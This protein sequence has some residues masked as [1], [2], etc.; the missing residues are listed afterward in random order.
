MK[1]RFLLIVF[2][3]L[4]LNS[5]GYG[6]MAA[7]DFTGV[8]STTIATHPA[9][10]Y[11]SGMDASNLITRGSGAA[12][13]TG[14]NSWRTVGFQNNGISTTN[15]DYFQITLS[16]STGNVMSLSSI[17]ARFAGTNSFWDTPGVSNQ[18]AYS[19]DGTTFTLIGSPVVL[20]RTSVT[21]MPQIDLSGI[22]ALQNVAA[23]TTVYIRYYASGQTNTGGWG[24][25]S[26]SSGAY[27][28][29]I[30]GTIVPAAITSVANG[31]WNTP[32]TWSCTCV[33]TPTDNVVIA[34]AHTVYTTTSLTRTANTTVHGNFELRNGGGATGTAFSYN[35]TSGGLNFNAT[36]SYPVYN[37]DVFWPASN[38]PYNVSVL[39]GGLTMNAT[40][41]RSV[42]GTFSVANS[43]VTITAPSTLTINGTCSINTGG[44]FN[45][46]PIYGNA[47]L[48]RYNTGGA[49][50][51]FNEWTS[52]TATIGTTPGYPNNVQITNNTALNYYNATTGPRAMNGNLTIDAG[53][54]LSFGAISTAGALTVSGNVTNA[55]TLTLGV[56]VGDDIRTAGNFVNTGTFNGNDRAIWFTKAAPGIQTVSS[57]TVP[58]IIPYVVTNNGTTVR[59]LNNVTITAPNNGNAIDFRNAADIIDLNGNTLTVGSIGV[60]SVILGSGS[61]KGSTASD[62]VLN[63][64]TGSIGTVKMVT[65]FNLRNFTLNRQASNVG[66]VMGSAVTVNGVLT[67]TNGLINLAN[68]TMTIGAS[69]SI[70]GASANNYIIADVAN[71]TNASLRKTTTT[72]GSFTFPIGDGTASA[73]G[74]QYSPATINFAAGTFSSAY[75]GVAVDDIKHPSMDA[76]AHYITRYW[77]VTSSG[78]TSPTYNFV[79]TYL[80]ADIVGTESNSLSNQWNGTAWLNNGS[81]ISANTLTLNGADTLPATNHFSAGRRDQ[82]INI[83][84]GATT[85]LTN[86]TYNFGTVIVGSPVDVVFT[87]QNTG[88][89]ILSLTGTAPT[90]AGAAYSV[91]TNYSATS[92]PAATFAGPGTRTFTI[93]FTPSGAGTFTG[94]ATILSNDTDEPSYIINFTGIGQLPTPEINI[95]AASGGFG[96]I[97]SGNVSTTNG[98]Q[99]TAF[100]NVNLGSNLAKD[101][102]IQN[103]GTASLTLSGTPIVSIGGTNPGDFVVTTPP[104]TSSVA[105]GAS[106]TFIITFTPQAVGTRSAIVSIA[107]NDSDENPYTYLIN[108]TGV[109]LAATNTITPTSGPVGTEVTITATTNNLT[110]AAVTISGV[111]AA[112]VTQVS[113]TQI[114]VT[115]PSGV[116][117]GLGNVITTNSQGCQASTP[118]TVIDNASTACQG[119]TNVSN[120]FIS[121]VTDATYGGLSYIEIYNRTGANVNLSGYSLQFFANGSASS[122]ATVNLT[123]T[124][125]NGS[126]FTVSTST[127]GAECTT[128][129]GDG[130]LANYNSGVSGINFSDGATPPDTTVGHDHIGLYQGG[131]KID[132][133]GTYMNQSWAVSLGIGDRGA[134]FRRKSTATVPNVTYSNA[135]WDVIDWI[136][137]GA[138][139][140]S[141]N[142]YSNIGTFNYL[143]GNPPTV[144]THPSFTPTCKATSLMVAGTEGYNGVGDTMELAYQWYAVAPNTATWTALTDNAIYTGTTSPTLNIADITGLVGYQYYCQIRESGITCYSASNAVIITPG[145]STTWQSDNTWSNGNPTLDKA[146][147]IDHTYDTAN[148]FSPSFEACSVTVNNGKSLLVRDSSYVLIRNEITVVAGGTA[149]FD[150]NSSLVQINNVTNSGNI[151]YKRIAQQRAVD[152]VYWSSPVNSYNL[153]T[154]PSDGYKFT[155]N[156]TVANANGTQG[157]WQFYSGLMDLGKGYIVGGPSTFHN[158]SNQDFEVPFFGVPR[159][160]NIPV[161]INRGSY[162]G[163]NYNL[164]NGVQVTNLDDNWNL[165]GNPYPSAISARNFL[166]ANNAVL[167]G[168]LYIWTHGTLP[169][170]STGNPFYQEFISNYDP[171]ADY[172]PLNLTGNLANPNPDYYIG[173]GQGFFAVMRDGAAGSATVNFTNLLR[174][175][176]YGNVTGVNFYR[177]ANTMPD[178]QAPPLNRIW[179]DI[180]RDSHKPV[181]T[182]FGY[183]E[184]ATMEVDNLYDAIT[185]KDNTLKLYTILNDDRFVIQGRSLPFNDFDQVPLGVD[186]IENGNYKIAIGMVDGLFLNPQQKIYLED[187]YLGIIH[188][189]RQEP[190]SFAGTVGTFDDRFVIKYRNNSLG[191]PDFE[192]LED[193]VVVASDNGTITIKSYLKAI[194]E[195][196]VYDILGRKLFMSKNIGV[197]DFSTSG[198]SLS[199]Q[200]VIVKV[201]LENG[202]L[203]TKKTLIN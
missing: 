81:N 12:W 170:T 185:K 1:L 19:L 73:N 101:F 52:D 61:F 78:I 38:S 187:K 70:T 65:D 95:R 148:A 182:M 77:S 103:T 137:S 69:G 39:Q 132:S 43:A 114:K 130:S 151:T 166:S 93:R 20:I 133:W 35:A 55:G 159:N 163:A 23:A 58:M 85:Y 27:G 47:S 48:L 49:Y 193:S 16:A 80:P 6:Q 10:V 189:L 8:G 50:N 89:L 138:G 199:K 24:F 99:N 203:V 75:V 33:P 21:T 201:K 183:V 46:A 175:V 122:Y 86:S 82:E 105:A 18:F 147:I 136:G 120:L 111:N 126:T 11:N 162:T 56:A 198:I 72:T 94:S 109:C 106:T 177:S 164:P 131:T 167:T 74:S 5:F 91:S 28:L 9:D 149:T 154:L 117:N 123:G 127:S 145:Q 107:N 168:A 87:I 161:T 62:L 202:T 31:D 34:A 59:L 196:T 181:R 152:Y 140:C 29:A 92:V 172:L 63:G 96:N 64:G 173:A 194:N 176:A 192:T 190:Y 156:T 100:G 97:T 191:N 7:W 113:A 102:E 32:G 135:D 54:A 118:F 171:N 150:N 144:T 14:A 139:S 3:T 129:G 84:Q 26:P 155:W 134:D 141:T 88:Q 124:I 40:M 44:S 45:N 165:L 146:V 53:S 36:T 37:G 57:T 51:R 143:A 119:G 116:I 104:A 158:S 110:G 179:L 76:S 41:A 68:N 184:G 157:N 186:I 128:S 125:N 71:G 174:N 195:V 197:N 200:S 30:G 112:P 178:T 2:F 13:S 115:V 66:C 22:S 98:L 121:E 169:S 67:L 17:D 160:G 60:N 4:L 42:A 83:V 90:M 25:N 15:T 153:S 180:V 108:G 142:D 188:D 79:G